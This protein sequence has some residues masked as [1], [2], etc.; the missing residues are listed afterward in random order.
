MTCSALSGIGFAV[1]VSWDACLSGVCML[2]RECVWIWPFPRLR[3]VYPGCGGDTLCGHGD[4]SPRK[5]WR[6]L[7]GCSTSLAPRADAGGRVSQPAFLRA[8][9][10]GYLSRDQAEPRRQRSVAD[11]RNFAFIEEVERKLIARAL[12]RHGGRTAAAAKELGTHRF[13]LWR[14]LQR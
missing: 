6:H 12:G 11:G 4:Q 8:A 2:E 14:K 13:T 5:R 9:V 7:G 10:S 3:G 1:K